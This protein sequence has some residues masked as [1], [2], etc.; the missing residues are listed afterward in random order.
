M[1]EA[2]KGQCQLENHSPE[3]ALWTHMPHG[4]QERAHTAFV[5]TG[6][7]LTRR[8]LIKQHPLE[9]K[10]GLQN[11]PNECQIVSPLNEPRENQPKNRAHFGAGLGGGTV[12]GAEFMGGGAG[13]G[14]ALRGSRTDGRY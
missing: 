10:A 11:S 12:S 5:R 13:L 2:R 7:S 1:S 14:R 4:S 3:P 6:A 8:D 9:L